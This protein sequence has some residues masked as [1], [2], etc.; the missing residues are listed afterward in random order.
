VTAVRAGPYEVTWRVAA[1]LDG[2]AKAVGVGG[3]EAPS[4]SFSGSVSDRAP[5]VRVADDGKTVVR[6]TR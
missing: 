3:G 4:G 1:G 2:K 6:G 5:D